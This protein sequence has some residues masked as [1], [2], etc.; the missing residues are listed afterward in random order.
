MPNRDFLRTA[1]AFTGR[2][3]KADAERPEWYRIGEVRAEAVGTQTP[4][5]GDAPPAAKS[6]AD[7]YVFERIG[8]WFGISADDFVRDVAG[9]DVDHIDL[10][11]NSP[12]GDAMEGVAIA[13]VLRQH[14]AEVTVWVD[15]LAA[16]AASVVAMAGDEVVMGVGAQL[17]IHDA[18]CLAVGDAA[19]MRKAAEML[20]ST[21]NAY[22]AAYAAKA[23]GTPADWRAVMVAETWYTGEEAVAA[24]LAD[25]VAT[26]D[27][28]ATA[29]GD[30][31]VPG[32]TGDLWDMWD[33]LSDAQRHT[34][35]LRALYAHAGRADAP[36]PPLPSGSPKTPAATASGSTQ[37]RSK[38]VAFTDEQLATM[39]TKLG[40][41]ANASEDDIVKSV[42]EVMDEFVKDD[43][44]QAGATLPKGT[45]A[46]DP[47]MLEQL[48]ADAASGR[49]ARE[50]Q[51]AEHRERLV[52]AAVADGR[53]APASR[54]KWLTALKNDPDG[55]A[56]LA[57]LA[58]GLIPVSELGHSTND[59]SDAADLADAGELDAWAE[60]LGLGEGALR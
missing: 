14:K 25:R 12:G 19:E 59:G 36:P 46:V 41:A 45:V 57:S 5:E 7:V 29:S 44:P 24:G 8:G 6:T 13:N 3:P 15:G 49:E 11:L 27:D 60:Q 52:Q 54:D 28:N 31:I 38:P 48:K 33:S 4:A 16:S 55:E 39:R 2:P 56:N 20:D 9:L 32:G 35:T 23:G 30:Q 42:A 26:K 53:I 1:L 40:L 43:S 51:R 17:M 18:S 50:Q 21:S 10:H 34:A 47:A 58:P 22:A 37:E